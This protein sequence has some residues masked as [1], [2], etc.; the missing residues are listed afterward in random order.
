MGRGTIVRRAVRR[1]ADALRAYADAR[2]WSPEEFQVFARVNDRWGKIHI[3]FVSQRFE[4]HPNFASYTSVR[5]FLRRELQDDPELDQAIG[6]VVRTP[7][8]VEQGGI[9]AIGSGY[10]E[11]GTSSSRRG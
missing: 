9:Y 11:I 2:G 4:N 7:S 3:I 6:L 1:I 5:D 8:Q 10:V